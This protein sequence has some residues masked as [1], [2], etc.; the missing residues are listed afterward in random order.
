[1]PQ[2][3]G[4][5]IENYRALRSVRMGRTFDTRTHQPLPKMVALVGPNGAGK[6]SFLDAL[7]F[8]GD[9]LTGNVEEACDREHRRGFE[10]LRTRGKSGPIVFDLYY[11]ET[12][13]SKP[14]SYELQIDLDGEGRPFVAYERLRQRDEKQKWGQP[15]SYLQLKNGRGYAWTGALD[16]KTKRNLKQSVK[17][18]DRRKLGLVS[19]GNL[20]QHPNIVRFRRFLEGWYLSYFEPS[21][22]RSLPMNGAQKHLNRGGDNLAN[23]LQFMERQLGQAAFGHL[24][25]KVAAAIPGIKNIHHDVSPDGRLL[26]Q[27]DERGY[28][29]PFYQLDMSDGSLKY[30]AYLLLLEDPDPAPLVGIEEPENGLHHKLLGTLAE[31]MRSYA[32]GGGPQLFVTTH[33]PH[34]VDALTPA[35]A[36]TIDKGTDGFSEVRCMADEPVVREMFK[37]GLPLGSVWF[38]GHFGHGSPT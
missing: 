33:S 38:S 23:Y 19:L 4:I 24:L 25:K 18:D 27:F 6:S 28:V 10:Q 26:I 15:L 20:S 22:A 29:D 11:R 31:S 35:E 34:F 8:I 36:W 17:L 7:G 3:E 2:L 32:E 1:M 5:R 30:L 37:E 21:K 9:C 13:N 16:A 14:I 12:E